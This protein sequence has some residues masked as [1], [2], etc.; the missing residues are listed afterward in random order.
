MQ[1]ALYL[2]GGFLVAYLLLMVVALPIWLYCE[3]R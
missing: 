3:R 2:A 1:V